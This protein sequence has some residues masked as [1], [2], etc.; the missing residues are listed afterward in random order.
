MRPRAFEET[1]GGKDGFY[2]KATVKFFTEFDGWER[3]GLG[4][5]GFLPSCDVSRPE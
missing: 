2:L 4:I 1:Y 5:E 3:L